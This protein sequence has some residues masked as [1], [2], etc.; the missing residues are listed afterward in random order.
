MNILDN[1]GNNLAG[2]TIPGSS[3]ASTYPGETGSN[4]SPLAAG[5][6]RDDHWVSPQTSGPGLDGV[7]NVSFSVRVTSDQP[8]VVGSD[9]RFDDFH[10]VPCGLLPKVKRSVL[11]LLPARDFGCGCNNGAAECL[12]LTCLAIGSA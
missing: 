10:S 12:V 5:A 4:T 6:T 7:T 9:F 8:I 3:P 11:S 1:A 2:V